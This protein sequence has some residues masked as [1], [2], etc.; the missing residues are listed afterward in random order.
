MVKKLERIYD[1]LI[2]NKSQ[3]KVLHSI[4]L[5][6]WGGAQQV[7]FDIVTNL[8]KEKYHVEVVCAPGGD[9]VNHLRERGIVVHTIGSL[10]R[11]CS[12]LNDLRAL[13]TL[14]QLIRRGRYNIVHCHSTKAGLVGRIAAWLARTPKIYFTV[15]GWGFY[16]QEEYG[17]LQR[18]LIFLERIAAKCST[19]IICVS[20]SCKR[21]AVAG[22]IAEDEKF[23]V[24]RNGIDWN[25][26]GDRDDIRKNLGF[27]DGTI[28]F[29]M[30]SRLA[31]PKNPL[32]FLQAAREIRQWRL[33]VRFVLVGRGPLF[34]DCADFIAENGLSDSILLLGERSPEETRRLI[35]SFDVL[36]LISKF[37]A[38]GL[39]IIEGMFAGLPII[40]SNVGGIPEL[41]MDGKNGF[42]VDSDKLTQ[43][44][45]KME[46]LT[47]N[48]DLRYSMGIC[49]QEIARENFCLDKMIKS[50]NE[51]YDQ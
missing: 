40:A 17:W 6:E 23:L 31:Y 37:E 21:D 25:V 32:M 24:I 22:A 1:E 34:K 28:V 39:A 50:Y 41:V 51:I 46:L 9:L 8:S 30:V 38:L 14:Y 10:K 43:L 12:P 44:T 4:T 48:S 26:N 18:L 5:S 33:E 47:R 29:G 3:V 11:D 7:L 15:H 45:G 13:F 27:N 16:N 20:E 49:N 35:S 42:L 36:V 19:K 2:K